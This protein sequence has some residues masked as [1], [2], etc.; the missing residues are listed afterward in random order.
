M[1]GSFFDPLP[2]GAGGYVLSSILHDW[3]DDPA[4]EILSRC[5]EAAGSGGT[6]LVVE[7]V[8]ADGE[9]PS[10]A[11]DL[12]MLVYSGGR[13]RGLSDLRALAQRAGLSLRA[14]HPAG[15]IFVVELAVEGN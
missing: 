1:V 15:Y 9:S 4:V 12:R 6:V 2:A 10:T 7:P 3:A 11:M 5:A 8:G 14:V 13:E